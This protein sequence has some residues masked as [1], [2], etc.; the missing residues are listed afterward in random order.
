MSIDI[1][2]AEDFADLTKHRNVASV[3]IYVSAA[4]NGNGGDRPAI[5]HDTEAARLALR[6]STSQALSDLAQID[7]SKTDQDAIAAHVRELEND[8]DFWATSARSVAVFVSPE[9][10]QSFRLMN[11]LSPLTAV[12]DRFDVGPLVRAISFRHIGYV[13]ALTEGEVRLLFLDSTATTRQ[14]ELTTLPDD[15]ADVLGQST[16]GGRLD[17]HKADGTLGPK[18]ELRRYCSIVQDAVL[19]EIGDDSVPLV[20]AAAADLDPAY[21]QVNTYSSL[22][23]ESIDANPASLSVSDLET[24]GRVI[25]DKMYAA[26]VADWCENFGNRKPQKRASSNLEVVA[27]AAT[28]GQV[29]SFLFDIESNDEGII[30]DFGEVIPVPEPGPTT[31]RLVDE[32]AARVLRTGGRVFAVRRDDLPDDSPLAAVF[33]G[34]LSD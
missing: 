10:I 25:L 22:V 13:L 4:A 23:E 12:G 19:H 24:R 15:A 9:G 26:A 1:P 20:L 21:R 14:I 29:E 33:R 30:N 28:A 8:R 11:K 16:S 27:Q 17:R 3:S 18:V 31:Y 34:A 2:S 6:T 7:V 5:A 32:V